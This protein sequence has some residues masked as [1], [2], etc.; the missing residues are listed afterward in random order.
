MIKRTIEISR[1]PAYL[2]VRMDQLLIKHGEETV[3]SIPCE[4]IGV[5]IVDHPQ[6]TYSH[7][8]LASLAQCGATVVICGPNHLPVAMVFPLADHCQVVWRLH[9]QL[10]VTLPVKK[11][12]WRQLVQAKVRGQA[13]NLAP[14]SPAFRRLMELVTTVRSGDPTNVEAQAARVYWAHWL[15]EIEFRRDVGAG[16]VNSFLN[17]GYAIVRAVVV[18]P[19]ACVFGG[20]GN[21]TSEPHVTALRSHI[22][23]HSG[24][25]RLAIGCGIIIE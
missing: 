20:R 17:Y 6:T 14:D 3:G 23:L 22:R 1:E 12:L 25:P 7:H 5:V 11:R 21:G 19:L 2:A 8:A 18:A 9:D 15:P 10:E 4:D 24:T 13:R 16:D